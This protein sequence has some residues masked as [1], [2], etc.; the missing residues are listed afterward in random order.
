MLRL[1]GTA[2]LIGIPRGG[3]H[4]D[5]TLA[6]IVVKG[7]KIQGNVVGSLKECLDAVELGCCRARQDRS[8]EIEGRREAVQGFAGGYMRSMSVGMLPVEWC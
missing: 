5:T 3:G 7:L 2:Y 4:I 6:E 8:G 1:G